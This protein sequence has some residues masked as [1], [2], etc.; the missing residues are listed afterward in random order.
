MTTSLTSENG[1]LRWD[2]E[3]EVTVFTCSQKQKLKHFLFVLQQTVMETQLI[4]V[5]PQKCEPKQMCAVRTLFPKLLYTQRP[6]KAS[7]HCS[8]GDKLGQMRFG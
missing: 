1:A 8:H 6:E 3:T 7:E 5:S 4:R 2:G